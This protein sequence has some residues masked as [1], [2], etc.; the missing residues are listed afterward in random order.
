MQSS[1][2]EDTRRR[3]ESF[4]RSQLD[5]VSDLQLSELSR[6]SHG[7]ARENWLFDADW[8]DA[9]GQA[10]HAELIARR[11]PQ[12]SL[13]VTDR[14]TEFALL[15]ALEA[16]PRLRA[17]R[18][19][20][21]DA[22]GHYL[23]RPSLVMDRLRGEC[24]WFVLNGP[25]P[26]EERVTLARE[27][28][29]LLAEVHR[30]D[31]RALGLDGVLPAPDGKPALSEV[32]RWT[33]LLHDHALVSYPELTYVV[34]WLIRN[35]PAAERVV[36]VHADFKPGNVLVVDGRVNALLDWEIAHLG[37]PMEDLGWITNPYR[38]NEQQIPGVWTR[39]EIIAAY[40]DLTGLEVDPLSLLY[41][42]V[43]ANFKLAVIAVTGLKPFLEHGGSRVYWGPAEFLDMTLDLMGQHRHAR[44]PS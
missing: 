14:R 43:F 1:D 33:S 30:T 34:S 4:L 22:D 35:A 18:V 27:L 42:N 11:D 41:W 21:L 12:A 28:L 40:Q 3:L 29:A 9:T 6:T 17:P 23:G 24:D 5:G 10:L 7:Y 15:Q 13:L 36:L 2:E 19:R 38:V 32:A 31:W 25:R 37:D 8:T 16:L 44:V 26:L 20:W 39:E